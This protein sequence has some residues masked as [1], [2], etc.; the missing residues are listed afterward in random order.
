MALSA[1]SGGQVT[2]VRSRGLG[3]REVHQGGA[4][5][6][7]EPRLPRHDEQLRESE[8]VQV[9]QGHLQHSHVKPKLQKLLNN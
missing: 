6:A 2:W 1:Y 8:A 4:G 9:Q 5:A 7:G 3:R